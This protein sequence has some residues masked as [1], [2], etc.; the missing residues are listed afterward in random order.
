MTDDETTD[1]AGGGLQTMARIR[2]L[3]AHNLRLMLTEPGPIIATTIMPLFMI[4]FLQGM[5]RAALTAS[6]VEE[7]TGAEQVVPGMA[8]LFSLFAVVYLGISFYAEHGWG[9]WDRLRTGPSRPIEILVGKLSP[10]ALV[11]LTQ[12]VVL[13]AVGMVA[14]DL[15][16][17]GPIG[18]LLVMAVTCTILLM[19]L[20]MLAVAVFGSIN[21][22]SA[23][24][25]VGAMILGGLGGAI[26]PVDTLPGWAQAIAP[27]SPAYWAVRGYQ[28]VIIDGGGL[29][30]IA[31]PV[32]VLLAGALVCATVASS[33]FRF[34]DD[35]IW[36]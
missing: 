8:V 26:A 33:L 23:A 21:Q 18:A 34:G 1:R 35:K 3:A 27:V 2:V 28:D 25:N 11:V 36:T 19:A 24:T 14:F 15:S 16:V 7:A 10:F 30:A 17:K 29:E 9:T 22:L 12:T 31:G 13:F 32:A 4:T 20:S 6:G 5:G